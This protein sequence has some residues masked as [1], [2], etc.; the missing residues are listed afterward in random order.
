MEQV[1]RQSKHVKRSDQSCRA[2]DQ[3]IQWLRYLPSRLSGA[4]A[5]ALLGAAVLAALGLLIILLTGQAAGFNRS[6]DVSWQT[7]F[8]S[9]FYRPDTDPAVTRQIISTYYPLAIPMMI[10]CGIL[11]VAVLVW[12]VGGILALIGRNWDKLASSLV[13]ESSMVVTMLT[14]LVTWTVLVVLLWAVLSI[15]A[16]VWVL[17]SAVGLM[18][19]DMLVMQ[20]YSYLNGRRIVGGLDES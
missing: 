14:I 9:P 1:G 20:L 3:A 17:I 19:V 4:V 11:I 13:G 16:T 2:R 7:I 18:V 12:A 5:Y 8:G 10:V 6:L 15:N